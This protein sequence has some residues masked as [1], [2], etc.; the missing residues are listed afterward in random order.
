[1]RNRSRELKLLTQ[2]YQTSM[3]Q[4]LLLNLGC[5]IFEFILLIIIYIL[6]FILVHF[7]EQK[8]L[9]TSLHYVY[10]SEKKWEETWSHSDI[11]SASGASSFPWVERL[12]LL[13]DPPSAVLS[14]SV[15]P[16]SL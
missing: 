5:L 10:Y 7:C 4:S 2:A 14:H 9:H 16:G 11:S 1:M 3:W 6:K 13:V 8:T 12:G 15:M